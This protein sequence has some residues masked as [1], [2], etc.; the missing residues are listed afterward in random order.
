MGLDHYAKMLQ[1][2]PYIYDQHV[3]PH[4][5]RVREL[6]SGNSR[7]ETLQSLGIGNIMIAPN[8]KVDDGIQAVRNALVTSW[9]DEEKCERGIDALRQ[10]H[11]EY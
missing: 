6:G 9:F 1:D 11:R 8:L 5:V 4:D 2:K 10:Y 3:L 7:L